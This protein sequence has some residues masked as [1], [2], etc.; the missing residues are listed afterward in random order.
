VEGRRRAVAGRTLVAVAREVGV[1]PRT[2]ERW[3]ARAY[4]SRPENAPFVEC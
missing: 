3:R 2:I 1:T 4:G